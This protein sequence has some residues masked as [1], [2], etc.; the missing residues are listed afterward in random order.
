MTV[1]SKG[2]ENTQEDHSYFNT[3]IIIGAII[4]TGLLS[5]LLVS[6][7]MKYVQSLS[8]MLT[9]K[10]CLKQLSKILIRRCIFLL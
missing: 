7:L 9:E 3:L 4:I 1:Q 10:P 6:G 8:S 2:L 5:L